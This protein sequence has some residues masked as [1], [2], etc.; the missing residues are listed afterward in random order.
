M[1]HHLLWLEPSCCRV[2]G[3]SFYNHIG[4]NVRGNS[5]FGHYIELKFVRTKHTS[6]QSCPRIPS[7]YKKILILLDIPTFHVIDQT[8]FKCRTNSAF[9]GKKIHRLAAYLLIRYVFFCHDLEILFML[10]DIIVTRCFDSH[11]RYQPPS[12]NPITSCYPK[13]RFFPET[14]I[15]TFHLVTK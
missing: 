9:P 11:N 7:F 4:S 1:H 13:T 3:F 15:F 5:S 8:T 6:M 14:K 10:Q 12:A 2:I